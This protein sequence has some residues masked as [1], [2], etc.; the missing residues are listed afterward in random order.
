MAAWLA[1]S[2]L[3]LPAFAQDPSPAPATSPQ[4]APDSEWQ[5]PCAGIPTPIPLALVPAAPVVLRGAPAFA[6]SY[7]NP[8]AEKPSETAR[9]I[10]YGVEVALGSGH[11][12]RG[13][14]ISDRLVV[15]PVAWVSGG[16]AE[17]S[18]WGNFT[19]AE[20]TDGSR[21]RIL[22]LELTRAHEGTGLTIAPALRMFFYHDPLSRYSTRS[23]EGWLY[24][25]Y[26]AGLVRLF[27]NQSVDVL[28][29]RG[30]YFGEAG[31]ESERRV[32]QRVE[33]GGSFGAGWAS[34]RF[35]D[36][37]ADVDKAALDRISAEG[38]LTVYVKPHRYISPHFE[39]STIV[40]P[41][42]RA[43]LARPTFFL[44]RLTTGVEF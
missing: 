43:A 23:I 7:P 6:R 14:I 41:G 26:D 44:V 29:Y 17:F 30:A 39:F 35:N 40:D 16:P 20:T 15:Q 2:G 9:P 3:C 21:P 19:L 42:V 18:L 8:D 11:A 24:L 32:S 27:T 22:E 5:H 31:I 25:S 28:T 4:A 37:Y 33:V 13:F 12:D 1:L 36:A 38:W 10:S 34:S